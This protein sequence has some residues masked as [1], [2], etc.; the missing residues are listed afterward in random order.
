MKLFER[1]KPS[2]TIQT[3]AT[4]IAQAASD[5]ANSGSEIV[6]TLSTKGNTTDRHHTDML[7]DNA[8]S[9]S[10]RPMIMI[11]AMILFSIMLLMDLFGV[12]ISSEL[13]SAISLILGLSVGFYFPGRTLEKYIKNAVKPSKEDSDN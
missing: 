11:W 7:S 2:I 5:V 4:A 6:S 13:K 10:I 12:A 3:P 1:K 9:K 8:L